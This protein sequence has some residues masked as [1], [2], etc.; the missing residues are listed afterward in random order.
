MAT[1]DLSDSCRPVPLIGRSAVAIDAR[2]L[3]PCVTVLAHAVAGVSHVTRYG[4]ADGPSLHSV[5]P[6]VLPDAWLAD[7]LV[8]L[9]WRWSC[10]IKGAALAAALPGACLDRGR[11]TRA[12]NCGPQPSL[13]K[14][15]R[16]PRLAAWRAMRMDSSEKHGLPVGFLLSSWGRG[17]IVQNG[18]AV[19]IQKAL[20]SV[21]LRTALSAWNLAVMNQP[22]PL[23]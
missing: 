17:A 19:L 11:R 16:P 7:P 2:R 9:A 3:G 23:S 20:P 13:R 10:L 6:P 5:I 18:M 4:H 1:P 15:G 14:K 21:P 12:T 22:L 8:P